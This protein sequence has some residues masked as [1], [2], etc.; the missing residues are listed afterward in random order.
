MKNLEPK[1]LVL[2]QLSQEDMNVMMFERAEQWLTQVQNFDHGATSAIM[3]ESDFWAWWIIQWQARDAGFLHFFGAVT[4]NCARKT[5]CLQDIYMKYH[6]IENLNIYPSRKILQAGYDRMIDSIIQ[7]NHERIIR[8][9]K[10]STLG[11]D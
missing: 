3:K 7:H 8:R 1:L 4:A 11:A 2:L 10:G 5:Q 9:K 6:S